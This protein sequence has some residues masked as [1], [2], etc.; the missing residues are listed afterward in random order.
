M[1]SLYRKQPAGGPEATMASGAAEYAQRVPRR[2]Q[3]RSRGKHHL[4]SL[5][6]NIEIR[7]RSGRS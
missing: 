6:L 5:I 1:A 2:R 4:H 7:R 3:R